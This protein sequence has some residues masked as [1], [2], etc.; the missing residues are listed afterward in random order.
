MQ[1]QTPVTRP[2]SVGTIPARRASRRT[3]VVCGSCV[4][5][6]R[7]RHDRAVPGARDESPAATGQRVRA[8]RPAL[9]AVPGSGDTCVVDEEQVRSQAGGFHGGW[10]TDDLVEPFEGEQGTLSW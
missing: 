3:E 10:N 7:R 2:R 5:D 9:Q 1:R 6:G 4:Q 8:A